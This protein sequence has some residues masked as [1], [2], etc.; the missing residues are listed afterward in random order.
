MNEG[1]IKFRSI[2][3]DK[4]FSEILGFETLNIARTKLHDLKL[5]GMYENGIGYGNISLRQNT[6]S[7][8][9]SGSA[10][11]HIRKLSI[12]K[13]ALVTQID[14][15][16]NKVFYQGMISP[17]SESMSHA[18]IY[19][20]LAVVKCVIHIHHKELHE[21]MKRND[22]E[23]TSEDLSYGTPEFANNIV[24]LLNNQKQTRGVFVTPG[25]EE[26]VFAY[27]ENVEEAMDEIM[28]IYKLVKL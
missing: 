9:I 17:S 28:E 5:I 7:L 12:E 6:N 8:L 20:A 10:T 2:N 4:K 19:Q 22:Y 16:Q 26:G 3:Q 24:N 23:R 13:Y 14:I 11:G 1:Y 15:S 25:H 27:G 18:V 21:Y